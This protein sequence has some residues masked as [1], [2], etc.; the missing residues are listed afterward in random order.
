MFGIAPVG[1][2]RTY[3]FSAQASRLGGEPLDPA[4]VVDEARTLFAD[5]APAIRD[6]L[7]VAGPEVLANRL[8]VA[9]PMARYARGRSS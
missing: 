9:P 5:A 3:W 1:G 4:E 2:T 6:L 8:W 7:A